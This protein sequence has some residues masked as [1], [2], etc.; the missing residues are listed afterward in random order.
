[1]VSDSSPTPP[2]PAA[3]CAGGASRQVDEP[4]EAPRGPEQDQHDDRPTVTGASAATTVSIPSATTV[5][6]G[7]ISCH[8]L[9][10]PLRTAMSA[11]NPT[12]TPAIPASPM[13]R[14]ASCVS[15][16]LHSV[17]GLTHLA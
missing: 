6:I 8:P 14:S 12:N 17:F 10:P 11:P 16:S 2:A 5:R 7:A 4:K 3:S 1:V 15:D 13:N 9:G